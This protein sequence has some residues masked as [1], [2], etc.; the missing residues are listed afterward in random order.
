MV[1]LTSI[2]ILFVIQPNS[3]TMFMFHLM[4]A[5]IWYTYSFTSLKF[6]REKKEER[7]K[8]MEKKVLPLSMHNA[9][10]T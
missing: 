10:S 3:L 2:T 1:I 6:V 4:V 8:K 9:R 5:L 7:K